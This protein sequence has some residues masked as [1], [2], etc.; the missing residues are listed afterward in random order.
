MWEVL[1]SKNK[2]LYHEICRKTLNDSQKVKRQK[3]DYWIGDHGF[4][5]NAVNDLRIN[6]KNITFNK[7]NNTIV[8]EGWAADFLH[9]RPLADLFV[10]INNRYYSLN[11]G[12]ENLNLAKYFNNDLLA[13]IGFEE[14]FPLKLFSKS[15][16]K[17]ISFYMI[18]FDGTKTYQYPAIEYTINIE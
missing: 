17:K 18:G 11:Y 16:R 2:D 15:R 4:T 14:K 7:R 6:G 3:V 5:L 9:N 13:Y 1:V 8:L 10:E 12:K